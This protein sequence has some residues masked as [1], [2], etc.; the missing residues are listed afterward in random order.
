MPN[1]EQYE[2]N[3]DYYKEYNKRPKVMKRI[4]GWRKLNPSKVR[5]YD[6]IQHLKRKY[7]I[8]KD[9]YEIMFNKQEGKCAICGTIEPGAGKEFFY[10]DHNH[11]TNA[12]RGLLCLSCNFGIGA[13]KD[14]KELLINAISYL[15]KEGL[16]NSSV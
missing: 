15:E 3:K 7:N 5:E 12:I 13:F 4:R 14:K 11:N 9:D 6:R 2:K 16:E 10:I 8:T 1:K